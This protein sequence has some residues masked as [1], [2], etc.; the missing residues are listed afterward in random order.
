MRLSFDRLWIVVAIAMPAF[1]A[2][3]VPMPAV[4]LAYQVRA[5]SEI[6]AAG[7][8]AA[9]DTWTFS[10][11]GTP[12]VDQ[13]WLSQVLLAAGHAVGGWELLY[14]ARAALVALAVG[15]L[16]AVAMARGASPRTAAT[17]ALAAFALSA[18]ALAL[19]P[20]LIGIV[21]FAVLLLLVAVRATHP[22]AYWLA[23]LVALAWANVHGSFVIAPMLLGYA[24]IEDALAHAPAARRSFAVFLVGTFATLVN[25]YGPGAWVYAAGI[26]A[27]PGVTQIVTEWQRTSPLRMPGALFYP[28]AVGSFVLLVRGRSRVSLAGWA[29]AAVLTAMAIWA[30]RGVA[31]WAMGMVFLLAGVLPARAN[32]AMRHHEVPSR[33]GRLNALIAAVLIG[34]VVVALPW[35]R[36][37]DPLAGRQG[38]VS[39][40][41]SGLAAHVAGIGP[42]D[43]RVVVPQTWGSWFEWAAPMHRYF[44]DSRFELFPLATWADYD[45]FM[46]GG[47]DAAAML[48]RVDAD[49]A[50]VP[51]A[52]PKPDGWRVVY[53]DAD[54]AL[55]ARG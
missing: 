34:L 48:D 43:Q 13:Q 32:D 31:W 3:L 24:W 55:L 6:V 25:P 1:V 18:G 51:S 23:P 50:V 30:E 49:M 10:I 15:L 14:V 8:L 44:V 36:P 40:A 41:P 37:S 19:R 11:A 54:G 38:I 26:G 35:W 45:A 2:L 52:W 4:D 39:Y 46:A 5:G 53:E 27:N 16:I 29:L 12:W 17:L 33:A 21:L 47:A 22:R 28:A 42:A 7:A 9:V 20:Q